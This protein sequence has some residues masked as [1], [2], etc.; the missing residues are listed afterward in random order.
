MPNNH[1]N[2][3]I[4]LN[5]AAP[6]T[7]TH[8]TAVQQA[9]A[10]QVTA[11]QLHQA[12]QTV[13]F[14]EEETLGIN[15]LADIISSKKIPRTKAD[16]PVKTGRMGDVYSYRSLSVNKS[17]CTSWEKAIKLKG[18]P[19]KW[20]T[21]EG[22]VGIEIEVENITNG[23]PLSPHWSCKEDGSLRNHGMEYVS[24]PLQIK[25]IQPALEGLYIPLH[26]SNKPDFSNRTS[27][28]IH[29][30]CRDLTQDQIYTMVLLYSIFEKH[31]YGFAG[32]KRLNS[33]FCVP[34]YRCNILQQAVDVIYGF[35]PTWHKYCGLNI[36]P[37]IDNNGARGYG[38]IEFRHLYGTSDINLIMNWIDQILCLRKACTE[39]KKEDL[40]EQIKTMN[41]SSDYLALFYRIFT[42]PAQVKDKQVFEEC[43]SNIKRELFGNEY[44]RTVQ[45]SPDSMYWQV[46]AKLGLRG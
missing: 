18:E 9:M 33:I 32:T 35:G 5:D 29:L 30:N 8:L 37:L 34:I 14:D 23:V 11:W 12:Q 41:T 20:S 28:H 24:V 21:E 39:I 40:L 1:D 7:A 25:Q 26:E 2:G 22:L 27:I 13:T 46:S 31:F 42:M 4:T 19:F 45:K 10:A 6:Q 38:T 3:W 36:L 16:A 15:A 43:I 44:E 17:A